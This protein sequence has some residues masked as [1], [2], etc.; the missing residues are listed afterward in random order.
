MLEKKSGE[1]RNGHEGSSYSLRNNDGIAYSNKS[2][3]G[4]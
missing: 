2:Y 3:E 4:P 1:E